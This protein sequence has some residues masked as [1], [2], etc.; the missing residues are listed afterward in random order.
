MLQVH[1]LSTPG[2]S[3]QVLL[4]YINPNKLT[5]WPYACKTVQI[6]S[7]NPMHRGTFSTPTMGMSV[8]V[9]VVPTQ[10]QPRVFYPIV[11]NILMQ[12][13][14]CIRKRFWPLRRLTAHILGKVE[15]ESGFLPDQ[16]ELQ[17]L[18]LVRIAR[19]L[20][21]L[22]C[23]RRGRGWWRRYGSWHLGPVS[24]ICMA[25]GG[26]GD[27]DESKERNGCVRHLVDQ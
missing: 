3:Q 1:I 11:S 16:R 9:H 22:L 6:T 27:S 25:S 24:C 13:A 19:T 8:H 2:C 10:G 23:P 26:E 4:P 15:L 18:N 21:L 20:Q 12:P 7:S 14:T 17:T 5:I